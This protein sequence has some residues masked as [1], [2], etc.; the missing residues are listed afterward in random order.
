MKKGCFWSKSGNLVPV[1]SAFF[2]FTNLIYALDSGLALFLLVFSI[3]GHDFKGHC[4]PDESQKS[5]MNL[6]FL[7]DLSEKYKREFSINTVWASD[8]QSK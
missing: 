4:H 2:F 5:C 1:A 3:K 6:L 7:M 8:W